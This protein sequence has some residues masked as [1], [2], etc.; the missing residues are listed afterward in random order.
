MHVQAGEVLMVPIFGDYQKNLVR[1][2]SKTVMTVKHL[3]CGMNNI[4]VW[5]EKYEQQKGASGRT[6]SQRNTELKQLFQLRHLNWD[7]WHKFFL[8]RH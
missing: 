3:D 2:K 7:I 8:I 4:K 5:K 1:E 6:V